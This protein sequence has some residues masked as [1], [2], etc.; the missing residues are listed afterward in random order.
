MPT[1]IRGKQPDDF[2][3]QPNIKNATNEYLALLLQGVQAQLDASASKDSVE[4]LS[5]QF[6]DFKKELNAR[7]DLISNVQ[8]AAIAREQK[9]LAQKQMEETEASLRKIVTIQASILLSSITVI[10]GLVLNFIFKFLK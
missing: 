2:G 3:S 1:P 6:D 5:K 7:L 10:V 9:A 8:I 4:S